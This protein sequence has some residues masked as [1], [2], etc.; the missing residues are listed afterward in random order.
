MKNPANQAVG[1]FEAAAL[2]GVH[3]TIPRLM[4]A[5]GRLSA[6]NVRPGRGSRPPA[7]YDGGECD[8]DFREYEKAFAAGDHGH[9]PRSW[10]H[11]RPKVLEH[12]KS[13]EH[14]IPFDDAIG[15]VEAGDIMQV[16]PSLVPRMCRS[17]AIVGRIAWSGRAGASR[18]WIVSRKSCL[19]NA[20]ATKARE[21][22]GKK[23]GIKRGQK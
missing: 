11:L 18:L 15:V 19:A 6:H 7:I 17:G 23:P 13:V 14:A 10:V 1:A 21:A 9:R 5:R 20:R 22:A 16:H 12:L 2:L 3:F 4:V 8:R